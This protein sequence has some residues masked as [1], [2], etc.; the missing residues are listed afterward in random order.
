MRVLFKVLFLSMFSAGLASGQVVLDSDN[1][2]ERDVVPPEILAEATREVQTLGNEILKGNMKFAVEKMYPRFRKQAAKRFGGEAAV[3]AAVLKLFNELAEQGVD[4]IDFR[5]E[6][7]VSGYHV[8]SHDEWL[9]F[10]PTVKTLRGVIPQNG[11]VVV[12]ESRD[13]QVAVRSRKEGSEWTF[14]NGSG[15]RVQELRQ[16][17]PTLPADKDVLGWPEVGGRVVK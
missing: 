12:V 5:A 7:A 6:P 8:P 11:K 4:L 3:E 13:F 14:I 1:S 16:L 9:V 2:F 17:F 10:V 15:L